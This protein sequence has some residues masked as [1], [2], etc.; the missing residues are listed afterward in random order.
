M[1]VIHFII[2]VD[3]FQQ[4]HINRDF[5]CCLYKTLTCFSHTTK[6]TISYLIKLSQYESNGIQAQQILF[7]TVGN[8]NKQ[9]K[10]VYE[11]L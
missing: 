6:E 11:M 3:M 4:F 7:K 10:H 2:N 1:R 9:K 5:R 8:L